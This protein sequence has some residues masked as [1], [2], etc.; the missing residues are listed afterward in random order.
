MKFRFKKMTSL[1]LIL[2]LVVTSLTGA[3]YASGKE[4]PDAKDH[5][6]KETIE[7]L[8]NNGVINGYPDGTVKPNNIIN[9]SE[10]V[11]LMMYGLKYKEQKHTGND[12]FNDTN[13][14]WAEGMIEEL[15]K[16]KVI[17]KSYYGNSFKPSMP[18]KRIEMIRMIVNAQGLADHVQNMTYNTIFSDDTKILKEDKGYINV[19]EKNGLISGFPDKTIRPYEYSTRAEAFEM[20]LRYLKVIKVIEDEDDEIKLPQK[21]DNNHG[22]EESFP[23]SK[24]EYTLPVY[25]HTDKEFEITTNMK[26]VKNLEWIIQKKGANQN[27]KVEYEGILDKTGGKIS[28]KS[29]GEYTF[30]AVAKNNGNEKFTFSKSIKIYP[31]IEIYLGKDVITHLDKQIDI[32]ASVTTGN[33]IIWSIYKDGNK[34]QWGDYVEGELSNIGGIISFKEIGKF[35]VEASLIDATNREFS[36]KKDIEVLSVPEISFELQKSAHTD[37][38]VNVTV[39]SKNLGEMNIVWELKKD[40]NIVELINFIDGSLNNDGGNVQFKSK[41]HYILSATVIDKTGRLIKAEESVDVYPVAI[42]SFDLP[43]ATHNDKMI[44]IKVSSNEIGNMK[45]VWTITK[46]GEQES[47]SDCIEGQLSNEGG[48]IRFKDKG[49]YNLKAMLVDQTGREFSV[50]DS[51]VVYPVASTGFYLPEIGHTQSFVEVKTDFKETYDLEAKWLI[52]KDGNYVEVEKYVDGNLNENGGNICFKEKGNYEL[53][54]GVTD[55]TGRSFEFSSQIEVYPIIGVD[56]EMRESTHTDEPVSIATKLS[57]ADGLQISWIVMKDGEK[58]DNLDY[59]EGAIGNTGGNIKFTQKGNYTLIAKITDEIGMDFTCSKSIKVYPVPKFSIAIVEGAHIDE[60][61]NVKTTNEDMEGLTVQWIAN[62]G[63]AYINL[64]DF[65]SGELTNTGGDIYFKTAGTYDVKAKVT[66]ETGREFVFGADN[67]IVIY[68]ILSLNLDLPTTAYPDGNVEVKTSGDNNVLPIKWSIMK[69][70]ENL[71]L[72]D[73]FSGKLDADGGTIKFLQ[74]GEYRIT[75]TMTDTL[76]RIF[77]VSSNINVYQLLNCD[78]SVPSSARTGAS[79]EIQVLPSAILENKD[80]VWTLEKDSASVSL[81]ESILGSIGNL[82]GSVSIKSPGNYKLI[83]TVTDELG[84][85]FTSDHNIEI[86]NTAP[87]K[88]IA[89][90]SVTRNYKDGKF[91]VDISANSTDADG[92]IISYE[93]IGKTTDNYYTVGNYTVKVRAKDSFGGISDWTEVTFSVKNSAP[94]VPSVTANITRTAKDG[95]FLVNITVSSTDADSDVITYEYEGKSA[96]NYYPVGSNTVR[97]RAKDNYGGISAWSSVTFEVKSSEPTAPVITRTP[98]GNSVAPGTPVTITAVS[99]DAD[100][101]AITY[102]WDNRPSQTY[103]YPLGKNVVKVKAV[104]STGVESPWSAIAFFVS[105]STNGGGMTLS[106]PDSVILENGIVGATITRYTFTVPP[107]SGHSG[108]DYGRVRGYNIKTNTWDQLDYSTTTNG[109]TFAR[110][111]PASTYLKL[112]FYYYTNHNCMYGKSNITYSV[113]YYFE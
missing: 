77:S 87:T 35:T 76:G 49:V 104:D 90:A 66:N 55:K 71:R 6:A 82:G 28:I 65:V 10:F 64:E 41:G 27:E 2:T 110:S 58:V 15:I 43:E 61:V 40:N 97:V 85:V 11:S 19:A 8:T 51:I 69:N 63:N 1:L 101:D 36:S 9:R 18:I 47:L 33:E 112:E 91:L 113:D 60:V 37:S 21:P 106:G 32:K 53:I 7:K 24:V 3:S 102:V 30:T 100:G 95:K 74:A 80:I 67:S 83:A 38:N 25:C 4:F 46:N 39:A 68:P 75:A 84:R 29:E 59:I 98:N 103:V 57:E 14:H 99:T 16:N 44:E 73:T 13:N 48:T 79:F 108:S 88:P 81:E 89:N 20:L 94:T 70:G 111:L 5:W 93:Y 52:K 86:I 56:F 31:A 105:D 23:P 62:D 42:M 107:V 54:A 34:V 26:N 17:S 45:A 72:E 96:D 78:F 22:D 12:T 92:D 109:I 50:E